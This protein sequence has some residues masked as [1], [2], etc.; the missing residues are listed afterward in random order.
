MHRSRNANA[1][2]DPNDFPHA[3]T[4]SERLAYIHADTSTDSFANAFCGSER[5]NSAAV[6]DILLLRT[7]L[8]PDHL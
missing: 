7:R 6:R 2:T 3:E 8:H 4:N 5:S 1:S